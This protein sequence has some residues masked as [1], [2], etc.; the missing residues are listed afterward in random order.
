M[1]HIGTIKYYDKV[2]ENINK[3]RNLGY[4]IVYEGISMEETGT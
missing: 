4:T 1:H 2:I 3:Y